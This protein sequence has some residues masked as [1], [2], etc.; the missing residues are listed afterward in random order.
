MPT[1]ANGLAFEITDLRPAWCRS[2]PTTPVLFHHGIG[3]NLEIF[4]AWIPIVAARH[5]VVR[6]DMRGF[7][8]SSVPPLDHTWSL[9]ALIDDVLIV[10]TEAFGEQQV[11]VVGESIG[12]TIALAAALKA[13]ARFRSVAMSNAAINGGGIKHA[14]GWR[15]EIT[16]MGIKRWSDRLVE[17]R[18]IPETTPAQIVDWFANTQEKSP[19]H[20]VIGLGE[21]L[22]QTDLSDQLPS[23]DLPLLLML[24]DRSPFVSLS[25]AS[26]LAELVPHADIAVFPNARHGLPL[27][28]ATEAASTLSAFLERV[29]SGR[30]PVSRS[31]APSA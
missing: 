27:S 6:F 18:F 14:P 4:D 29:E 16:R 19:E 11:H 7:G 15:A 31:S 24:P 25:Q 30:K 20:V 2:N 1:T 13:P 28:H 12:G 23:L 9:D 5:P 21:L 10:A 17:M 22:I 8:R 3:A 26:R